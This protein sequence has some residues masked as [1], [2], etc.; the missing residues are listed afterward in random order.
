MQFNRIYLN[1]CSFMW[2]VGHSN[3]NVFEYFEETKDIDRSHGVHYNGNS[4]FNNYDWVRQKY[5]IGGKLKEKLNIEIV[6]E[7]IYGGSLQRV[8]RKTYNWALNNLDKISETLFILEWPIGVRKEIYVPLQKRYVNYTT[9][10][11]NFDGI[12]PY[13]HRVLINEIEPNFFNEGV[14]YLEDLHLIIGLISFIEK[15]NGK[16]NIIFD[17]I[18][19]KEFSEETTKY[20]SQH[21][22]KNIINNLIIPKV[23]TFES[24]GKTTK[25]LIEFFNKFENATITNDTKNNIIDDHNS[26]RGSRLIAE[27]I[28]KNIQ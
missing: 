25:S 15:Q 20:V 23:I 18:P 1:G 19:F 26:I 10:F 17:E 3:P 22:I 27:Q 7:S 8:V 9:N 13:L 5:N 4:L 28:I 21:K 14:V 24:N 12:D 6:D 16:I 2:G 11:D